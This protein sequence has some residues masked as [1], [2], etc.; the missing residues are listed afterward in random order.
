MQKVLG[1]RNVISPNLLVVLG[2]TKMLADPFS[3]F[4]EY[5]APSKMK[6]V[7]FPPLRQISLTTKPNKMILASRIDIHRNEPFGAPVRRLF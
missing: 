2:F 4:N 6:G 5:F 1:K 7:I 3:Y